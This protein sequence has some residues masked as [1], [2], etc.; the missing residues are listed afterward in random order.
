MNAIFRT[1]GRDDARVIPA[2]AFLLLLSAAGAPPSGA[3][4]T[5]D[6][7]V[8]RPVILGTEAMVAAEHPL[9]ALAAEEVLRAGGNAFD[10]RRRSST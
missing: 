9:E 5:S 4:E 7:P 3:Q 10:A 1:S 8:W 2:I 6:R